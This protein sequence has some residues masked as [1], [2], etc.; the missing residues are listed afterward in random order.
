MLILKRKNIN[1]NQGY[2]KYGTTIIPFHKRFDR[3]SVSHQSNGRHHSSAEQAQ[4]S[5]VL[6]FILTTIIQF[7]T[8]DFTDYTVR[9]S[10]AQQI[11]V[12]TQRCFNVHTTSFERYGRCIDVKTTSYA[13]WEMRQI[14]ISTNIIIHNS[15][16]RY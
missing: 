12:R 14:V 9:L 1:W 13:Y 3:C 16:Y 5:F 15:F 4:G 2:Y 10:Q 8:T 11:P 6:C 7:S